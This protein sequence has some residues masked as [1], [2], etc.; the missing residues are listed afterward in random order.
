MGTLTLVNAT[1]AYNQAATFGGGLDVTGGT[2]TLYNTLVAQNTAGSP[3][4]AERRWGHAQPL[5][6]EQPDR[7]R[8][9]RRRAFE[10]EQRQLDRRAAGHRGGPRG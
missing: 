10:C 7:K 4:I 5:E 2:A 6:L 3:S 9:R 8:V 1:I